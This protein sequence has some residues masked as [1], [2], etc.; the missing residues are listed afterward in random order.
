MNRTGAVKK[1]LGAVILA[2]EAVMSWQSAKA[3]SQELLP[4]WHKW[5]GRLTA[6]LFAAF[7]IVSAVL[8]FICVIREKAQ[9]VFVIWGGIC[10]MFANTFFASPGSSRPC[11][12]NGY[13][14]YRTYYEER[15]LAQNGGYTQDP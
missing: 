11:C 14:R 10:L 1:L 3:I 2:A 9:P 12:C 8:F 5:S 6:G 4:V 7:L 13:F 15:P